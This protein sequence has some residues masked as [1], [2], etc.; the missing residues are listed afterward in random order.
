M[1]YGGS[2]R[3]VV[4][5]SDAML[6]I[7][8]RDRGAGV[9]ESELERI[10]EPFHRLDGSRNRDTG[11]TG[12]GLAIARD[13]A[14]LHGG[15]LTLRNVPDGGLEA[16]VSLP[17]GNLTLPRDPRGEVIHYASISSVR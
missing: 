14:R 8:V 17:R 9:P 11:G 2:A 6:V 13:I 5:D 3:V 16:T 4:E 1:R 12:L 15:D 7:R 10:F